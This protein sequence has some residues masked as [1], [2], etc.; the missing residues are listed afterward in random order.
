MSN[1]ALGIQTKAS[2]KIW[3]FASCAEQAT[4]SAITLCYMC[5]VLYDTCVLQN[6]GEEASKQD[7]IGGKAVREDFKNMSFEVGF[8]RMRNS[9]DKDA[10]RDEKDV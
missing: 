9:L 4:N 3:S 2:D 6:H 10:Q 1:S 5:Y 8:L 7:W